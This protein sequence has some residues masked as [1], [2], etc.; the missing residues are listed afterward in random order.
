MSEYGTSKSTS[1][2]SLSPSSIETESESIDSTSLSS[3]ISY[4]TAVITKSE[5]SPISLSTLAVTW[6]VS[7]GLK[8]SPESGSF[9]STVTLP[10]TPSEQM[11][12]WTL[13]SISNVS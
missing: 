8:S 3:E 12:G 10:R 11:L 13:A 7:P 5:S 6:I 1:R 9:I 2:S 4:K